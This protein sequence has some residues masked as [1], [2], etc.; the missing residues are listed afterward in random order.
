MDVTGK[1][2]QRESVVTGQQA[3]VYLFEVGEKQGFSEGQKPTP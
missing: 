2:F 1:H 3:L